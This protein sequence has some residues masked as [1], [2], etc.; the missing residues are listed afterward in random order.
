MTERLA[1]ALRGVT[2]GG[3]AHFLERDRW[4]RVTDERAHE[5]ERAAD[6]LA[7][8]LLAP[9]DAVNPGASPSRVALVER[10]TSVFGLPPVQASQYA[11]ALRA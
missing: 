8:E 7:F 11:A 6:R 2:L 1:G 5:S 3:G 9:F 4:G 10:L